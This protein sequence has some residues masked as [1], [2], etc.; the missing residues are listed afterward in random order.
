MT[1]KLARGFGQRPRMT[2]SRQIRASSA[3]HLNDFVDCDASVSFA[4]AKNR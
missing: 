3:E 1:R 2:Y 4:F